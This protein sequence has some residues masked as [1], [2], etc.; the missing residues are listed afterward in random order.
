[1]LH[2]DRRRAVSFG[3]DPAA[4]DR[5]RPSYPPALIDELMATGPRRVLD[6]GCGTGKAG[7]L[8]AARGCEVLGVEADPRMAAVA[9]AHGLEV[10]VAR[11]EEWAAA[12]S[13]SPFA[14]RRGTGSIPP[15]V[16][17]RRRRC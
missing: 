14:G 15:A 1:M 11:F 2:D 13:T 17:R 7:R 3:D 9:R 6:V 5:E 12:A 8:L 16:P 4:Y 10:E